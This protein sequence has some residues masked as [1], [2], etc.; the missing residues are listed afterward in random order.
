[1]YVF[2]R[3]DA[4]ECATLETLQSGQSEQSDQWYRIVYYSDQLDY[5]FEKEK[6]EPM[7]VC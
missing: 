4:I 2:V 3:C 1:M 7:K 6:T 5:V